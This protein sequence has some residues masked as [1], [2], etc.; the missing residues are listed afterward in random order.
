MSFQK[1]KRV[2]LEIIRLLAELELA[3]FVE[4]EKT[5]EGPDEKENVDPQSTP[6][7]VFKP[8][9]CFTSK[10][11]VAL[12]R[13]DPRRHMDTNVSLSASTVSSAIAG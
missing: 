11:Q 6:T 5:Q 13:L 1:I 10:L 8:F 2:S 4:S 12:T 9:P 7:R 3:S